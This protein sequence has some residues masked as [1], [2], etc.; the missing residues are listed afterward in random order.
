MA[1]FPP[2]EEV[3]GHSW[4]PTNRLER[5]LGFAKWRGC[6]WES[7]GQEIRFTHP[8]VEGAAARIAHKGLLEESSDRIGQSIFAQL[9]ESLFGGL[10]DEKDAV[11]PLS[12]LDISREIFFGGTDG[13]WAKS[14]DQIDVPRTTTG[15][16]TAPGLEFSRGGIHISEQHG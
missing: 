12:R 2:Y 3:G 11:P 13:L 15:W 9:F 16:G 1:M 6:R 10:D 5:A 8:Y 7:I 14:V 4:S